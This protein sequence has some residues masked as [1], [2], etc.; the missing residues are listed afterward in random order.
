LRSLTLRYN[1]GNLRFWFPFLAEDSSSPEAT[2]EPVREIRDQIDFW[3]G[4]LERYIY[5][6]AHEAIELNRKIS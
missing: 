6:L 3:N 4:T 2:D 1:L 5:P